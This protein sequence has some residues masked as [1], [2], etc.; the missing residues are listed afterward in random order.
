[1]CYH[2]GK[3][4]AEKRN[5]FYALYAV[6]Q[7]LRGGPDNRARALRHGGRD[8][9]GAGGAEM[10]IRDRAWDITVPFTAK[11]MEQAAPHCDGYYLMTPL[12]K[13]ALMVRLIREAGL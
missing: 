8:H 5:G 2:R 7:A 6:P 4:N 10:C 12:K 13:V 11:M 9:A 1:M 3:T